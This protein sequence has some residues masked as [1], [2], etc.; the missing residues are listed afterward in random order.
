M[1]LITDIKSVFYGVDKTN[2]TN[3]KKVT[4][5]FY[6]KDKCFIKLYNI[7]EDK[8]ILYTDDVKNDENIDCSS[9]QSVKAPFDLLHADIADIR[10]F[11]KSATNLK[12]CLLIVD[13]FTSKIY[14]Y[15]IKSKKLFNFYEDILN[16]REKDKPL[17]L[18]ADQEFQQN[19][20]KTLNSKHNIK[21][22]SSRIR[23]EKSFAAEQKIREFK[24]PL[25]KRKKIHKSSSTK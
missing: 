10:F 18:Q 8:N 4:K 7:L 17:C 11:A 1:K 19:E 9:L 24:K 20:I 21:N 25:F 13:L 23:G 6:S 3:L 5:S 15:P 12:Y 22:F 14:L 16:K 2:K